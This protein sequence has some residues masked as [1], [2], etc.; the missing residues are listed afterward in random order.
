MARGNNIVRHVYRRK[1]DMNYMA[2][3]PLY[4]TFQRHVG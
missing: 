2:G 3:R 4:L 1:A